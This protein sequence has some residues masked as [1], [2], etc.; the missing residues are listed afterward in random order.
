MPDTE[1]LPP[2][3]PCED[4]DPQPALWLDADGVPLRANGAFLRWLEDAPLEEG[5]RFLPVNHPQL[6][7]ACL[8]QQRA[9]EDVEAWVGE[10]GLLW[11]FIPDLAA[12]RV[13]ARC[14]DATQAL[15]REQDATR[16]RRLYRLIT[17]NTTDLISRHTPDGRFL[18]ASPASWRLLGYWPE[19]LRGRSLRDFLHPADAEALGEA[20][21]EALEQAGYHTATYR[22]QHREG[23]Y[24]WFE[25]ASRAIRE[26]YTGS[27]VEVVSVARDITARVAA[28]ARKRQL[29][30]ELA[31]TARLVMLGELASG[32][33][34]EINQPL[35]A[36]MNYA[37]A[38]QRYLQ[39]LDDNPQAEQRLALGL[40]KISEH[41]AHASA[42]IRRLRAFLRKGQRRVQPLDVRELARETVQ[43]CAWEAARRQVEIV[44]ALPDDL[45]TLLADKVLL[46]QVLLNLLRN[47]MEANGE[48][49]QGPSRVW[50]GARLDEGSMLL[51]VRDQGP[52]LSETARDR[53]FTP[54]F[55][56]KAEGLGLGLSMSRNIVEGFGGEL[57]ALAAP[58]GGLLMRCRLPVRSE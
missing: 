15:R 11:H 24:L 54:F 7:R 22:L 12:G 23:H 33:A 26:T 56:S 17:E 44:L 50:L 35:A 3:L 9:I 40:E 5:R 1:H 57:D 48:V 8:A 41:A 58:Q 13:L 46:E 4:T 53:I 30:D 21:L 36:V 2:A 51:E 38:G 18:D 25:T 31:H 42:V 34:H 32:I 28:D 27:V 47:A 6:A 39:H 45:P 10:R 43:L 16:A 19:Q 55:T 20:E 29:E 52:G 37:S 14:R 49:H